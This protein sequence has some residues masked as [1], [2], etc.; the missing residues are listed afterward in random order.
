ME[1]Q[2]SRLKEELKDERGTIRD[3]LLRITKLQTTNDGMDKR[4]KEHKLNLEQL[5]EKML[6]QQWQ[7]ETECQL[8]NQIYERKLIEA[9]ELITDLNSKSPSHF[10][11]GL[12]QYF[13]FYD[14][15][16]YSKLYWLISI[17]L[18]VNILTIN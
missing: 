14:G 11:H 1:M 6:E 7:Q 17:S 18:G 16:M 2:C 8:G 9:M 10:L 4:F 15:Y 13:K 5:E 12:Y 3:N